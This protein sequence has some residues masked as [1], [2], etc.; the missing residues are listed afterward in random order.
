[1]RKSTGSSKSFR[2]SGPISGSWC[3]IFLALFALCAPA[4]AFAGTFELS[5]AFAF[6][7][8]T[9][10]PNDAEWDRHWDASI[11]YHF[12]ELSEVELSFQDVYTRTLIDGFE[13]T[14]FH[15]QIF[16]LD[17]VQSL[18]GK[19]FPVQPYFK[20]GIGQLDREASGSYSGGVT[21]PAILDEVTG[22]LGLGARI[23]VTRNFAFKLEGTTYLV[24]GSLQTWQ[25]NF[26][27][28]VGASVF[29]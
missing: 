2:K 18:T 3:V 19:D 22:I 17:W 13:D 5:F 8:N 24:G 16:S 12:T 28:M 20:L 25:D 7:D 26:A 11:G 6:N 23:F 27:F 15:D 1:M 4:S 29:F 21:A 9:Y 14:S 10:A